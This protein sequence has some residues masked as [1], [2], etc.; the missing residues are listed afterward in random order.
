MSER[1]RALFVGRMR[2]PLPL[3]A[4]LARKWDAVEKEL[5]YRIVG[6]VEPG[7]RNDDP[8]FALVPRFPVGKLDGLA[9]YLRLPFR[10]RREIRS[11]RPAAVVAS[12]PIVGAAALVARRLAGER[13]AVVVE[14]HGD[15]RTFTR[16]YGSRGRALLGR[17]VDAVAASAVRRADATRAVSTF[18]DKLVRDVRNAPATAT[19]TAYSDLAA[20]TAEPVAPLPERPGVVF[21]GALERYKNVEGLASAWR[22]LAP[23]VPDARLVLVGEGSQRAVVESLVAEFPGRVEHHSRLDPPEVARRIDEATVLAL[24]SWPEGLGRVVIEAFARGRPVVGTDG[25]GIPDLL[26]DGVEGFLVPPFDEKTLA[27]RLE[28]ILRDADLAGR[29]GAAAHARFAAWDTSPET[30]ATQLRDL[31][32]RATA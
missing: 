27:R 26:T 25:G 6:S 10:L 19:F 28:E 8:R 3:P 32:E 31:V 21:V 2:Y 20:F 9:F 15:W 12:D 18:T 11:F 30:L 16:S 23:R 29:L 24:P 4:W 17:A 1:P 14:V 13:P 7:N 5:D 22:I